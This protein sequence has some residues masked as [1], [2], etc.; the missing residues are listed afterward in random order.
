MAVDVRPESKD[1]DKEMVPVVLL[2]AM[3]ALALLSL[4][5]VG[6]SVA[7]GREPVGQPKAADVVQ[8]RLI[9]LK[10][11]GAQAVTVLAADG[12]VIADLA[13]GGFITVVQNGLQRARLTKGVDQSLPVRLVRFANGRLALLDPETGWSAELYA[14][15]GDNK[16]AFE[17]LM[18]Q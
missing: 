9:V 4:A 12:T 3:F 18:S 11:G 5:I 17:R 14:F 7:T 16:A 10:G 15:G 2:R 8:E 1:P 13:H 6:F